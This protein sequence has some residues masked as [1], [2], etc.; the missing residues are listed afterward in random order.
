M[1]ELKISV[2]YGGS[3]P[4]QA[5]PSMYNPDNYQANLQY[6]HDFLQRRGSSANTIDS[7]LTSVRHFHSLYRDVTVENL[8]SYKAWLMER[9]KPSTVNTRIYGINQYVAALQSGRDTSDTGPYTPAASIDFL[10]PY[11]LPSVRH[12]Q[13]PF[14][15]NVIS[16]RDYERLKRGLKRDNNMF[17]YFVVRF[18]G[19]TG[20]RVSELIQIKAEHVQIGYMDLYSKGGKLRRIYIPKLLQEEALAWLEGRN[21]TSGFLFLNK[22]GRRITTRGV[23]GQLKVMALRYGIDPAVAYPHSFR[24]RFAKSFLER[25]ND[26]ALLA[27]LMGHESIET[28][29]IYLRRTSTEQQAIVDRVVDW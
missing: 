12:Q 4:P 28:T 15:N 14:L 16:K 17:W 29:R 20:A 21:Q 18:L 1:K 10:E 8:Q 27:D 26:L 3:C 9:Y 25:F 11:K 5:D 13:K 23:A 22:Q 6:F 19:A 2:I 7:Y 24:H